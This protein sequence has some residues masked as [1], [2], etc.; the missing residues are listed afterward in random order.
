MTIPFACFLNAVNLYL[1]NYV[2]PAGKGI[3][4]EQQCKPSLGRCITLWMSS[5]QTL[6]NSVTNTADTT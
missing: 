2:F 1:E 6:Q 4:E 3:P 5:S